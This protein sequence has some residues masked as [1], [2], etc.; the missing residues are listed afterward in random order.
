M[1]AKWPPHGPSDDPLEDLLPPAP[2]RAIIGHYRHH[3]SHMAEMVYA[4]DE[5]RH[6]DHRRI[7]FVDSFLLDFR[8]LYDFPL[9]PGDSRA[10]IASTSSTKKRGRGPKLRPRSVW[11]SWRCL[12]ASTVR[13]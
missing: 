7:A 1:A 6:D 10:R 9:G 13:T 11:A 12:L 8:A 5:A 2:Q 3:L 4:V